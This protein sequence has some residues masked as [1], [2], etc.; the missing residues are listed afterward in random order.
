M[1]LGYLWHTIEYRIGEREKKKTLD[2][3]G[4]GAVKSPDRGN[5]GNLPWL[6]PVFAVGEKVA[7]HLFS[8]QNAE[9]LAFRPLRGTPSS[10]HGSTAVGK[11]FD[12]S[13]KVGVVRSGAVCCCGLHLAGV[14]SERPLF[15]ALRSSAAEPIKKNG[16]GKEFCRPEL[17]RFL[18]KPPLYLGSEGGIV[19]GGVLSSTGCRYSAAAVFT[20]RTAAA[21]EVFG[22]VPA[23]AIVPDFRLAHTLQEGQG[24]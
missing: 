17:Y 16:S 13:S 7:N 19:S 21:V 5:G 23:A 12:R 3:G 14:C 2:G 8:L 4:D 18:S 9:I 15:C 1:D 20:G 11:V 10:G 6:Y 24:E 22:V